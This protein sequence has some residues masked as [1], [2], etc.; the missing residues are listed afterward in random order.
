MSSQCAF[1][2]PS[3]GNVYKAVGNRQYVVYSTTTKPTSSLLNTS[4]NNSQSSVSN[5]T[6][7]KDCYSTQYYLDSI[8]FITIFN[9]P[10]C[11][12][13]IRENAAVLH[14]SAAIHFD[15]TRKIVKITLSQKNETFFDDFQTLCLCVLQISYF[16]HY[17]MHA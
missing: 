9:V 2:C 14:Y 12:K 15:L 11:L 17:A 8:S 7:G 10:L 4:Y 1:S 5:N 16:L 6:A 3:T 13:K